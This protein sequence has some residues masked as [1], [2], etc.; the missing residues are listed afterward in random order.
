MLKHKE[1]QAEEASTLNDRPH[2]ETAEGSATAPPGEGDPLTADGEREGKTTIAASENIR[3]RR[4]VD[5][6]KED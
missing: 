5:W 2:E 6:S 3:K 4:P 1:E